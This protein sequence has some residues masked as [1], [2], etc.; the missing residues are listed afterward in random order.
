MRQLL[1]FLLC[2]GFFFPMQ[3][4][5]TDNLQISLLTVKPRPN[6]V[7]TI[8]GHTALRVSDT[9]RGLDVVFNWGTFN[10]N[11]PNFIYRFVK[12]EADYFL[13]VAD[14]NRFYRA[15]AMDNS[16]VVEQVFRLSDKQKGIIIQLLEENSL[17]ENLVYHY[18]FL[19]DNCTTRV[20][21]II[22]Q[23]C[24]NRLVYP[25]QDSSQTT[26]RQLI[27]SCTEPYPWMSFG[28][29]LIIGC[30]A[31]SLIHLN[32]ELFLP[33]RLMDTLEEST[34]KDD[35]GNL[36]PLASLSQPIM[37]TDL[38][39]APKL[40]FWDNPAVVGWILFVLF[41]GLILWGYKK[42]RLYKIPFLLLFLIAAAGGSIIV[43]LG[44]CSDHPCVWPNWNIL[45]LHPLHLIPMIGY[46]FKKTY[47]L[48]YWYHVVNFVLLCG[49][50][51]AWFLIPQEMNTA[52]IP[53]I[54]TLLSVSGY[55]AFC[56]KKKED[57]R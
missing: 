18:N 39:Q 20:R 16:T 12:G 51:A 3:A 36:H 11:E 4:Q 7:Y 53:Y 38:Y 44:L 25:K 50:F 57:I 6:E 8:Y 43:F 48:F 13:S 52:N 41:L 33:E 47:P 9:D 15:Y 34:I 32:Q 2:I 21:D 19:F 29:D 1:L 42:K 40:Y 27:N 28:I 56:I 54:L 22:V 37:E 26:F 14:Y 24:D 45:W 10:F 46:F 5:E 31:D 35:E 23:A 30:G 55:S 17:P 49:L